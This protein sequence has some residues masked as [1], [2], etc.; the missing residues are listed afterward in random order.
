VKFR[1]WGHPAGFYALLKN[2]LKECSKA[3]RMKLIFK[4]GAASGIAAASFEEDTAES[5]VPAVC[6]HMPGFFFILMPL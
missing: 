3:E 1:K 6:R 2:L 4:R 5:P